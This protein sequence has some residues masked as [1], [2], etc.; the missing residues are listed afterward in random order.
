M[1]IDIKIFFSILLTIP[2]A[3]IMLIISRKIMGSHGKA[4]YESSDRLSDGL[5]EFVQGIKFIKSFNNSNQK[6]ESLIKKMDDFRIKSLNIEGNLSPLMVLTGITIDFGLV[7]LIL[8]GSYQLIG[9]SLNIKTLIIF[10]IISSRYFENLKTLSINSIKIKYLMIAG[11]NV[12]SIL[13]EKPLSGAKRDVEFKHHNISFQNVSFSYKQSKVIKKVNLEIKENTM[14][15]FVGPSGSGKTTMTHL[16]ARFFDVESGQIIVG[17]HPIKSLDAECLLKELSMVFQNVL[18]FRDTIYNNILIGN[19]KANKEEV[20]EAAKKSNCHEFILKLPQGYD[21]MVGEN[22]STLSGGEQQ[23]I[24]IARAMLKNSPIVLLDE[25]TAS[26][27]P[28]NELFIQNA[29][30]ELLKDKTIIVIA[31]RLKT[32]KNA[33]QIVVFDYGNIVEKG[34]HNELLTLKKKYYNMWRIQQNAVG[35][36]VDND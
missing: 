8:I 22:G 15:A 1:G 28:E 20:I 10:M 34:T 27:D 4:L 17:G 30:S 12:K 16:L 18:L 29:I 23:R 7:L 36:T 25:A 19:P 6:L 3:Y 24:S 2:F 33:D 5:L 35:W 31:H 32:I 21:T 14:T 9:G 13:D 26:L 11:N